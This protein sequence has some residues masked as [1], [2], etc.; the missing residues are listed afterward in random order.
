MG[1]DGHGTNRVGLRS[2]IAT[3][4]GLIGYSGPQR[5]PE[6]GAKGEFMAQFLLQQILRCGPGR[7]PE[8]VK[9]LHW[10]HEQ[11]AAHSGSVRMCV[12]K[13]LGNPTDFLILRQWTDRDSFDSFMASP[14]GQFPRSKPPGIYDSLDIPHFWQQTLLTPGNATGDFL[15][16]SYFAVP[17]GEW[18]GFLATRAEDDQL[19]QWYQLAEHPG[20]EVGALVYSE[21]F[22]NLEDDSQ[23]LSIVRL[24]DRVAM[25]D[26]VASPSRAAIDARLGYGALHPGSARA[27]RGP[28]HTDCFEIVDEIVSS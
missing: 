3:V 20:S 21:T 25:E 13:Y 9:R 23:A 22:R 14:A 10:I 16:R 19:A 17:H 27:P 5:T 6:S 12:A 8:A 7:Q 24:Q 28:I 11:M 4:S 18:E 26:I 2:L 1:G 15:W